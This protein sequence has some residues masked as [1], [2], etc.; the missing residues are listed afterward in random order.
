MRLVVHFFF[1]FT[2]R[3]GDEKKT[4]GEL[5]GVASSIVFSLGLLWHHLFSSGRKKSREAAEGPREQ[6]RYKPAVDDRPLRYHAPFA[7]PSV[8]LL[9]E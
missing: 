6:Q 4:Y 9:R 8:G 3:T 7:R 1:C 5:L 2:V